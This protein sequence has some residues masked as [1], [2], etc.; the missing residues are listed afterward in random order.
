MP[1]LYDLD[2]IFKVG[3]IKDIVIDNI[4]GN[5]PQLKNV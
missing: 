5:Q 4:K 1:I 2:P 3:W